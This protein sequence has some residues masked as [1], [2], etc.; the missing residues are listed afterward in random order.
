[1]SKRNGRRDFILGGTTLFGSVL[2]ARSLPSTAGSAKDMPHKSSVDA[3]FGN[4]NESASQSAASA[5]GSA[6]P[7][8]FAGS[9]L[10]ERVQ[11]ALDS[12]APRIE[13]MEPE[14]TLGPILLRPNKQL[15]FSANTV[16]NPLNDNQSIFR[17]EDNAANSPSQATRIYIDGLFAANRLN[18]ANVTYFSLPQARNMVCL[19]NIS[20]N[21]GNKSLNCIGFHLTKLNW[22]MHLENIE[23]SSL[24]TGLL[25]QSAAACLTLRDFAVQKCSTGIFFDGSDESLDRITEIVIDGGNVIQQNDLG[26][27][28]KRT[29]RVTIRGHHFE[30]NSID[31]SADGDDN[32]LIRDIAMRGRNSNLQS[33][34]IVLKNTNGA[35][36]EYPAMAGVRQNG[37]FDVDSSNKSAVL[38]AQVQG[39]G[40]G[41]NASF[42]GNPGNTT[43]LRCVPERGEYVVTNSN[44]DA[45]LFVDTFFRE[46]DGQRELSIDPINY[47]DGQ[48]LTMVI[49]ANSRFSRGQGALTMGGIPINLR[50]AGPNCYNQIRLR[51]LPRIA[52]AAFMLGETS[53]WLPLKPDAAI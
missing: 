36:I 1:M 26:I 31:I 5:S 8:E 25:A 29:T 47:V 12:R 42:L 30:N 19:R 20:I 15:M 45:H 50:G 6:R 52:G 44:P 39:S 2:A 16:V 4:Q 3:P 7:S 23:L 28:L 21:G 13:M 43:G 37:F 34:G 41:I 9:T 18:R 48:E 33:T 40:G 46:W 32:L 24:G 27:K 49:I 53:G 22:L 38:C 11:A 17:T 51:K 10:T 35:R 14:Y